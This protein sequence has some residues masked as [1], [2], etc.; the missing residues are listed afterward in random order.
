MKINK[1]I[2]IS[3]KLFFYFSLITTY[4]I[5][6]IV[7]DTTTGLDWGQ[8]RYS[9]DFFL[10]KS[11][12]IF[13]PQ[14][15]LYFSIISDLVRLFSIKSQIQYSNL[16]QTLNFLF[17]I[18]GIFGL[19]KLFIKKGIDLNSIYLS[20]IVICYFPPIWYLRLTMKPEVFAFAL[21]PWVIYFIILYIEEGSRTYFFASFV[22][23]SLL[24]T[25]KGSVFGMALI[26]LVINFSNEIKNF[27][28]I[29][30]LI[31]FGLLSVFLLLYESFKKTGLWLFE[32]NLYIY[33]F[34]SPLNYSDWDNRATAKFFLSID[35]KNL[36]ENPF[37]YLHS[38]SFIS[39]TLLDTLSDYFGFFWNHKEINNLIA[40]NRYEFSENFLIQN[41][42]QMYLSILFTVLFY[43]IIIFF[44]LIKYKEWKYFVFPFSG[45]L[46][47]ILNSIG[48][49]S[50][51]FNPMTGDTFKVHYYSFLLAF[52]FS[53]LIAIISNNFK[54]LRI[55][56]MLFV[57]FF[58]LSMGFPKQV[59]ED[60]RLA[61]D[62]RIAT[63]VFCNTE[64]FDIKTCSSQLEYSYN[65]LL[66]E[67][68]SKENI[69][70]GLKL[71]YF[72]FL[73]FVF[74]IL[75]VKSKFNN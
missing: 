70:K 26:C 45:L 6:L 18:I 56:I 55:I 15:V 69:S 19:F 33:D 49:P 29:S 50:N 73:L 37:K 67:N 35:T 75:K 65:N 51:N 20:L 36:L 47:L 23:S 61:F 27:K 30:K 1:F 38:D 17:F 31:F 41:F 8:Y 71:N 74:S 9:V 11:E 13:D 54:S 12:Y 46:V 43:L 2:S 60:Y 28:K 48:I 66:Y 52:T 22:S 53:Y 25:I 39:I 21:F 42:F 62:E 5:G 40:F 7:Y 24:L 3:Y 64:N 4:F 16:V 59:T 32:K 63:T 44:I 34:I 10:G 72:Y 58:I 57:P 68:L 14:G